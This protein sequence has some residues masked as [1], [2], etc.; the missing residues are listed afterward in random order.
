MKVDKKS[1]K[2]KLVIF[3]VLL[4]AIPSFTISTLT[5]ANT[6]R[7][8]NSK[9]INLSTRSSKQTKIAINNFLETIEDSVS[10]IFAED[11]IMTYNPENTQFEAYEKQKQ[12]DEI[13]EYILSISLMENF[14][15]FSL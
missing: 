11:S 6:K 5:Y 8:I 10:L 14:F 7:I 13:N 15:D 1:L 3:C 4:V 2:F 12:E 9:I